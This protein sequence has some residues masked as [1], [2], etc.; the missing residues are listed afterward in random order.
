MEDAS[1]ITSLPDDPQ[2]LKKIIL[3][4]SRERDERTRERDD[5]H[6]KFLRVET[7]LL[8]LR[9]WYYG[10]RADRLQT[11]GDVAQMLLAFA[12]ELESRPV[13]PDDL[14]PADS[15][16][17]VDVGT[18]RRVRPG[19]RNLAA[20]ENLPVVRKEHDLPE[21]QKP[22]PCCGEMRQRIGQEISWQVEFIPGHFERI[23]HVRIKYA[24]KKCE[25][26]AENPNIALADKPAQPIDKGMAGPG[27]L[28]YVVTSKFSDFLPLYRLENIFQ[29]N[30]LEISRATQ[31][32][33][34]GDVADLLRPLYD[35]MVSRVL[36][37]H[38][39]CTDD[40]VMPMLWPEKT[41]QARMWVYVG[42]E[43]NPYNVFDFTLGR[44]RDGPA[45]FLKDYKQILLADAYGGYDGVVVGNDIT[46]AGCWAHGRRKFVD[47]E[48]T[49]PQIAAEAVG[50]IKRLYTVEDR[51]KGLD[52]GQ[53]LA[54]RQRESV[55]VLSVLRDKLFGWRDQLL[56]KHPMS[57]AV[58]YLLNQWEELN[59]FTT[60][61][62]VPLDNNVSEREMKR[63]CLNRKNSLF[64]GNERGG[65]TAAILSSL[66]STCRQHPS[67]WNDRK[68]DKRVESHKSKCYRRLRSARPPNATSA[69]AAGSGTVAA[70]LA[71]QL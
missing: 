20:L 41:K 19:R 14:P 69:S 68:A 40:T 45:T 31:S 28:A 23:E 38:V 44:G 70:E 47:A 54:L 16:G 4:L 33:W 15:S 34:C 64:V 30:G 11:P 71:F 7:E 3:N 57:E 13:N 43:H 37:S 67:P 29:R 8:R 55:P 32:V 56:P 60:D 39:I 52:V 62:A 5:W 25:Q 51:G 10:P 21:D 53:R 49:H 24:C 27:L 36:T 1:A 59:V 17:T 48:K 12:T 66:T 22:C 2:S 50:I 63:I 42:D 65:A 35:L 6:V 9:K 46:R 61:G 18:V 26:N 58:G